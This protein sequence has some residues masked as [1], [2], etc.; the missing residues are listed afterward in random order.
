MG[1]IDNSW[2]FD[3]LVCFLNGPVWNAPIQSFIEEKSLIFETIT[4]DDP[5]YVKIFEEYKNL[6]D[7]MLAS[8]MEDIGIS[9]FQFEEACSKGQL[10]FIPKH[11]DNVLFDQIWA[12]NDYELFKRMMTQRNVEL[13]LQALELIEQ[14]YGV[15]PESFIPQSR[16]TTIN[17][18]GS[19]NNEDIDME[20]EI[21]EE[22][23]KN[24][25]RKESLAEGETFKTDDKMQYFLEE[26]NVL[27]QALKHIEETSRS[28][29]LPESFQQQLSQSQNLQHF[30][31]DAPTK[32]E[33][34]FDK[35]PISKEIDQNDLKKRQEY[36]RAQRDKLVAL[37]KEARKKH[38]DNESTSQ[39]KIKNRPKSARVAKAALTGDSP[40]VSNEQLKIR[41]ALAERLRNEVIGNA[42]DV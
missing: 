10:E 29:A 1:D 12:A 42:S 9:P 40:A 11:F 20:D 4:N 8:Y 7:I 13:Q 28:Q 33:I 18:G 37:K 39:E 24:F 15:M 22:V 30:D 6:V 5:E 27:Q 21:M 31:L 35:K 3:S 2:I 25:P 14:K 17:T 41:K 36:L 38:L 32:D 26:K 34:A 23:I 16:Q 19:A